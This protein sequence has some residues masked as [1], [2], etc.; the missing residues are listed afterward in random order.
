MALLVGLGI[1]SITAVAL[2]M[3]SLDPFGPGLGWSP[4][5]VLVFLLAAFILIRNRLDR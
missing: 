5:L 2:D 3:S 1:A 4:G